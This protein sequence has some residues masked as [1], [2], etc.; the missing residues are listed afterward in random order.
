[1]KMFSEKMNKGITLGSDDNASKKSNDEY[2]SL[3][4]NS[5]L[6]FF[7]SIFCLILDKTNKSLNHV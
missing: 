2:I 6:I 3:P 1:M 5:F 7:L 4:L